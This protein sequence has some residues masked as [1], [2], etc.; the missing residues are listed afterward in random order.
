MSEKKKRIPEGRRLKTMNPMSMVEPFI[1]KNRIGASNTF[2]DQVDL[3]NVEK[4]IHR[5]RREGLVGFGIMHVIVAAYVRAISQRPGANRFIRGQR[6]FA[7]NGI[8]VM[9]DVKKEMTR[10]AENT[11]IKVNFEPSMTAEDVYRRMDEAIVACRQSATEFDDTAKFFRFIPRLLLKFVIW[12]INMLDYFGLLPKSLIDVSPFHGSIFI[13]SMGSL[14]IPAISHH[15]YDFGNLPV[16]CVFGAK[17]KAYELQADGTVKECRYIDLSWT[18]DERICDGFYFA[19][20]LKLF[21]SYMKNP[22]VLDQPPE[23][24]VEDIR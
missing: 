22:D 2:K 11:C 21:W 5:K 15:L 12:F 19:S 1:M 10:E 23:T 17:R 9:L 20:A 24:V 18:L 16:F 8:Q 4:Y 6:V 3:E 13:S 14:G 7:R